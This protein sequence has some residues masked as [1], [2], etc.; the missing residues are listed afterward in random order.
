MQK[1]EE[2]KLKIMS[3][4]DMKLQELAMSLKTWNQVLIF[5][6]RHSGLTQDAVRIG[7]KYDKG[8]FSRI[9]SGDAH[10]PPDRLDEFN[11]IVGHKLTLI[12][13]CLREGY[14]ARVL[15][16]TLEETI[17]EQKKIIEERDRKIAIFEEMFMK[18]GKG[19][20]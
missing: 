6:I 13:L 9:M 16:K 17:E 12:W 18:L 1:T 11:D 20:K 14:E 7:M 19:E 4:E 15:P 2:E 3:I 10:L 5:S 8:T